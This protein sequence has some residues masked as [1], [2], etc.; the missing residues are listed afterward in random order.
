MDAVAV[1]GWSAD[2]AMIP[3]ESSEEAES[4]IVGTLPQRL[5]VFMADDEIAGRPLMPVDWSR[6]RADEIIEQAAPAWSPFPSRVTN[7]LGMMTAFLTRAC[8][9]KTDSQM[10]TWMRRPTSVYGG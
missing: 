4:P 7:A 5:Y 6:V 9:H 2:L 10:L 1:G 3:K 8:T